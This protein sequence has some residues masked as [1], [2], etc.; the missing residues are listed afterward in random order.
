[1]GQESDADILCEATS[2]QNAPKLPSVYKTLAI[3]WVLGAVIFVIQPS[4]FLFLSY[5]PLILLFFPPVWLFICF[6]LYMQYKF[7]EELEISKPNCIQFLGRILS[8]AIFL[9][10]LYLSL[11]CIEQLVLLCVRSGSEFFILSSYMDLKVE[12]LEN[13]FHENNQ[14]N[15]VAIPFLGFF[16]GL[17]T[18]TLL[19]Y[20]YALVAFGLCI[21][22]PSYNLLIAFTTGIIYATPCFMMGIHKQGILI[23]FL[24]IGFGIGLI[25]IGIRAIFA[26]RKSSKLENTINDTK[27][28]G[29]IE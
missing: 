22:V 9:C 11:F 27:I 18:F 7:V 12:I 15:S 2:N 6:I 17:A 21:V 14:F 28:I 24:P 16:L 4:F 26:S 29:T 1:M 25:L 5:S 20:P 19:R 8:G 13:L 23:L 3:G 10:I